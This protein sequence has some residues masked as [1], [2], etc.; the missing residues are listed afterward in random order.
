MKDARHARPAV[1]L[2]LGGTSG[3]YMALARWLFLIGTVLFCGIPYLK[4]MTWMEL[5][6]AARTIRRRKF[7]VGMAGDRA[8][9]LHQQGKHGSITAG[10]P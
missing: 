9:I 1:I 5:R 10:R 4:A 3:K 7:H 2:W 8:G 6:R